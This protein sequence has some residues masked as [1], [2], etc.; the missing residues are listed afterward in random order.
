[1]IASRG[2][3]LSMYPV[4]PAT[5]AES[6]GFC[7]ALVKISMREAGANKASCSMTSTPTIPGKLEVQQHDVRTQVDQERYPL[8]KLEDYARWV[9]A[10]GLPQDPWIRASHR[11]GATQVAV[12]PAWTVVDAPLEQWTAWTGRTFST[13]GWH[14]VPH[15]LVPIEVDA[16]AGIGRYEEPRLWMHSRISL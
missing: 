2:A 16:E 8:V 11:L 15:A 3:L 7:S 10:A 14:A 6:T 1:M 12:T 5:I 13:S 4:A 9:R